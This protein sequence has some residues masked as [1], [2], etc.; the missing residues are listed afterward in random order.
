MLGHIRVGNGIK[1]LLR[2]FANRHAV[3]TDEPVGLQRIDDLL[4][5]RLR[6]RVLVHAILHQRIGKQADVHLFRTRTKL[7][8]GLALKRLHETVV[9]LGRN[10]GQQ[11]HRM[12]A[13]T[14]K[15]RLVLAR[16]I[17]VHAQAQTAAHLLAFADIGIA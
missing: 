3:R 12:D 15:E 13:V 5:V 2:D 8:F 10:N 9:A 11:V 7:V 4:G 16:T 14:S 1:N 6:E 17:L